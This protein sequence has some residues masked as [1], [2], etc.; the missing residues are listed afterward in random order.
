M[1]NSTYVLFN[2]TDRLPI[3]FKCDEISVIFGITT[4]IIWTLCAYYS[5]RY[6]KKEKKTVRYAFFYLM[7]LIV[8]LCLDL[9]GNLVTFYMFYELMTLMSVPLVFHDGTKEAI[10]SALKYLFYSLCGAYM[11]LFGFY[12]VYSNAKT[13]EFSP[14]GV[15][16]GNI[17]ADNRGIMMLAVFLMILSSVI[18][19]I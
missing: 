16:E 2:L 19:S 9:A 14:G 10:T 3:I 5:M 17:T 15:L 12:F 8:L 11:V 1:D 4:L 7:T 6:F 18:P 13:I